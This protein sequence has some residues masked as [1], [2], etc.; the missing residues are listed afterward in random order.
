MLTAAMAGDEIERES[1]D[2]AR[3]AFV[4]PPV[5]G[6]SGDID[7][8]LLDPADPDERR[9]L[10]EAEHPEFAEALDDV[11]QDTVTIEGEEVNPR[12]HLT[13]HEIVANQLWDNDPPEAWETAKRLLAAGYE[14]HE[15]LHMLGG[16]VAQQIWRVQ[17]EGKPAD[18]DEY[19]EE[20]RRLPESWEADRGERERDRH[21]R[22]LA[23]SGSRHEQAVRARKLA[24]QARKRNRGR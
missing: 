14:R 8:E 18:N 16:A 12:L 6:E 13:I 22:S 9:I 10:I 5:S 2:A 4:M 23:H 20:L 21:Q 11:D 24:R 7:L 19:I 1:D 17:A 15:I 3:R